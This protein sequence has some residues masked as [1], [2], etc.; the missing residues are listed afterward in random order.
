MTSLT[1]NNHAHLE[2]R[3]KEYDPSDI[4]KI[5]GIDPSQVHQKRA[6]VDWDDNCW[7][8]SSDEVVDSL[9]IQ[10]H[11]RWLLEKIGDVQATFLLL[12]QHGCK[13][14]VRC[15][16]YTAPRTEMFFVFE[17]DVMKRLY[18]LDLLLICDIFCNPSPSESV[19]SNS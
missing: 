14:E 1:F 2:I 4:T 17:P 16:I 5:V 19:E 7:Y 15:T 10:K 11:L 3:H 13:M 12:R 18:E 9:D 8:L 6:D